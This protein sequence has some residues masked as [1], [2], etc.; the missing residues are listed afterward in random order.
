MSPLFVILFWGVLGIIFLAVFLSLLALFLFAC[1]K[2]KRWLKWIS[3]VPLALV[4]LF[5]ILAVSTV[6]LGVVQ[7]MRPTAVF[8]QAFN[9]SPTAITNLHSKYWFFADSGEMFLRFNCAPQKLAQII[10]PGLQKADPATFNEMIGKTANIRNPDW[11]TLPSS[12]S[13]PDYY[14]RESSI[15]NGRWFQSETEALIYDPVTQTAF[16]YFR[17]ID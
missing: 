17:G 7:S 12:A 3:G 1:W 11:W 16:Y 9:K 14:L 4:S 10:P 13:K 6:V 8:K 5:A 2:K 15:G